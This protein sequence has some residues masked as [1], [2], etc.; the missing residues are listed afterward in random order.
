M[1]KNV[2]EI[3]FDVAKIA[4]FCASHGLSIFGWYY[5]LTTWGYNYSMRW[6]TAIALQILVFLL[7][8]VVNVIDTKVEEPVDLENWR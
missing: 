2:G 6:Y 5:L 8:Y 3:M 7:F 1:D 4:L